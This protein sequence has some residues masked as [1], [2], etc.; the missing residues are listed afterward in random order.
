MICFVRFDTVTT[1]GSGPFARFVGRILKQSGFRVSFQTKKVKGESFVNVIGMK[2]KGSRPFLICSHLDTVP[3]GEKQKWTKTSGNPWKA[4]AKGG[5]L[6]GLGTADDK[7]S[8]L[9]MIMAAEQ[10][11]SLRLKRPLM[12]MGTFGEE[13]GMGGA[14]HF[15]NRWKGPKPCCALVGEP[16]SLGITYRHK[17]LGVIEIELECSQDFTPSPLSSPPRRGRGKGEGDSRSGKSISFEFKGK[18]AH[19]SRPHLGENAIEKAMEFLRRNRRTSRRL[20]SIDGGSAANLIPAHAKLTFTGDRSQKFD[21]SGPL[22]ESYQAVRSIVAG[23]EGRKDSSFYP[24]TITSNFGIARTAGNVTKLVFDF[25]LL[26]GQSIEV[27]HR[28]LKQRLSKRLSQFKKFRWRMKIERSNPPLD[29]ELDHPFIKT[30]SA[31]LKK[32]G[33]AASLTVKPSCTEA[34]VYHRW[35]VPSVIFGPGKADGNIHAPNESIRIREIEQ[36][37]RIY[38]DAIQTFCVEGK[39]CF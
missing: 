9:A 22:L 15:V 37:V 4:K 3:P 25:R 26:P 38:Q 27:I 35:G 29:L 30:V 20:V 24:S 14:L 6:Y 17:G 11:S 36:A 31:L 18:Q 8:L 23:F 19:S 13:S 7:G 39:P 10:M 32:R 2:G 28:N 34:G 33:L 1:H 21:L 12:V 16:T 5:R